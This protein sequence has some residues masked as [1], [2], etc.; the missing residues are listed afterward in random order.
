MK[1]RIKPTMLLC[2]L[3]MFFT[4]FSGCGKKEEMTKVSYRLKWLFNAS[5]AGDIYADA[6]GYFKK[7]GLAVEV[8]EGGPER[9]AIKE[10]EMGHAQF[11]VASADQVIR[12]VAKGSPVVV[13]AQLFQA[14][15]LQWIYRPDE[16][17]IKKPEDIKGKVVGVTFGG[18]DE[19]IMKAILAKYGIR[20]NEVNLFS[21]RYDY[22]PF[23]EKRVDLWPVYRNAQGIIIGDQLEKA[24]EKA[25]FFDPDA[26]GIRFVANSVITTEK[27]IKERPETVKK[28]VSALTKAWNEA[29]SPG[30]SDKTVETIRKY[31][32]DTS[33]D[34]VR[35]QLDITR[36]FMK[37]SEKNVFGAID[38]AA[39]K[40]TE[41][42]MLE[43]KLIPAAV[44]IEKRLKTEYVG[45]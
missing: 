27:M 6:N 29:L 30:N 12:A 19:T 26:A 44:D 13:L 40:Q 45:Q 39:W 38:I 24:G 37:P 2:L 16:V 43:Q 7:E 35:R 14:N 20:E 8:K 5:V 28:F 33:A 10:L 4:A 18:N 42:I 22:T 9:D 3:I 15:P 34:V 11:G 36:Q 21:V 25:A 17:E 32:R 1:I 23:Y 31:D 41:K